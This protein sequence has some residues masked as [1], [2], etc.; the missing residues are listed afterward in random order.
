M[1]NCKII[2][3]FFLMFIQIIT[4]LGEFISVS[5]QFYVVLSRYAFLALAVCLESLSHKWSCYQ[6]DAFQVVMHGRLKSDCTI[7]RICWPCSMI[8]CG[9]PL[10]GS[11][12]V[13]ARHFHFAITALIVDGGIFNRDEIS[14]LDL[15]M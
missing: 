7:F 14:W 11:V 10:C 5:L 1:K 12:A 6:S 9:L 13:I 8:L 3:E 4:F 15:H 2:H